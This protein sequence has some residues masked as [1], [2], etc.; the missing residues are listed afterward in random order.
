M[1]L[2]IS[3]KHCTVY[4]T[5]YILLIQSK[6]VRVHHF[7]ARCEHPRRSAEP[8]RAAGERETRARELREA[9]APLAPGSTCDAIGRGATGRPARKRTNF[10]V[11]LPTRH[12]MHP[13]DSRLRQR[14]QLTIRQRDRGGAARPPRLSQRFGHVTR[15]RECVRTRGVERVASVSRAGMEEEATPSNGPRVIV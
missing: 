10:P 11:S 6:H 13:S 8:R 9:R 15:V 2:V 4:S 1:A 5:S 3:R 7:T 12:S 14:L